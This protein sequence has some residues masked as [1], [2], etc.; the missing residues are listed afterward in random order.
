VEAPWYVREK[1]EDKEIE[2]TALDISEGGMGILSEHDIPKHT[3]LALTFVLY[4]RNDSGEVSTYKPLL[5]K[6]KVCYSLL[7]E[8]SK[9]H[10]GICFTEVITVNKSEISEFVKAAV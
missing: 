8:V 2:A 1:F 7:S 5:V 9:Y 6:G 3:I 10:L 4:K